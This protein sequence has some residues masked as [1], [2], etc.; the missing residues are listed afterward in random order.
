[1]HP[2]VND[3]ATRGQGALTL[4]SAAQAF[5][6]LKG[7]ARSSQV[8]PTL[9][10][11]AQCPRSAV[12]ER[13]PR[14]NPGAHRAKPLRGY[15]WDGILVEE[16]VSDHKRSLRFGRDDGV[17]MA[18]PWLEGCADDYLDERSLLFG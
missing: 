15:E 17:G 4:M 6:T 11:M 18:S 16:R 3:R 7:R 10:S 14:M 1:M 9:T 8:S 12:G 5:P 2:A 13:F